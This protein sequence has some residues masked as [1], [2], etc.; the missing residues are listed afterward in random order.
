M[1]LLAENETYQIIGSCMKVH[2]ELGAG[3]LE[4]VYQ[5]AVEKT[6]AKNQVPYKLQQKIK[7]LFDGAELDKYFVADFVCFDKIILEIKACEYISKSHQSQL[8]NY[9]KS[10]KM[11]IGLLVNFGESSLNWKRLINTPKSV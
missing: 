3:F 1:A 7:I 10:T 5:E 2:Q 11:E 9:L 8:L 4:S 6:F